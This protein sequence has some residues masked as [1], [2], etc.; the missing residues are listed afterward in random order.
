MSLS[1]IIEV[2]LGMIVIYYIL[3]L[4]VSTL[5]SI[6]TK[7]LEIRAKDLEN[8]LSSLYTS[9]DPLEKI[10]RDTQALKEHVEP[11][12]N[13]ALLAP[14]RP[15]RL[16]RTGL[17]EYK[18]EK[19]PAGKYVTALLNQYE[20]AKETIDGILES[21]PQ[22]DAS[23][24][25]LVA[26]FEMMK[27][28]IPADSV[29]G[30]AL[31]DLTAGIEKNVNTARDSFVSWF[32]GVMSK[33]TTAYS[34]HTKIFVFIF[35][36]IVSFGLAVDSIDLV[37]Q[38]W[39]QPSLRATTSAKATA[40]TESESLT[41]NGEIQDQELADMVQDLGSLLD[42]L[43]SLEF[44]FHWWNTTPERGWPSRFLGILITFVAVA[45]GAPFWY[46][47]LRKVTST[48]KGKQTSGGQTTSTSD[49]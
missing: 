28:K 6:T 38:L 33:A 3:S 41:Q 46:D 16:G 27:E 47:L 37:I 31:D 19:I 34:A 1:T 10:T 12:L 42:E 2:V 36:F 32:D 49:A 15:V 20:P 4:T 26:K 25:D 30:K 8:Y 35:A 29:I 21:Y 14:Y 45:Q 48:T 18:A 5:T 23:A 17:R 11:V 39:E 22:M 24:A 13:H 43:E 9:Q 44:T 40:I 7:L